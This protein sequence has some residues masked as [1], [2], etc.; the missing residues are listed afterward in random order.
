L[1]ALSAAFFFAA[2]VAREAG[3]KISQGWTGGTPRALR[4]VAC[5]LIVRTAVTILLGVSVAV[6]LR[7]ICMLERERSGYCDHPRLKGGKFGVG[8]V[9]EPFRYRVG[10]KVQIQGLRWT[11]VT[12]V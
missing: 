7:L 1:A 5:C 6:R 8:H 9:A 11:A 3:E 4:A 2:R 12:A 10:R